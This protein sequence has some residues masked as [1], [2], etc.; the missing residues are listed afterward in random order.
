MSLRRRVAAGA[1]WLIIGR[2]FVRLIGVTSTVILARLLVPEDFGLIALAMSFVALIDIMSAFS[3]DLALI[4]DNKAGQAEY[5]AAWSMG[6][7]KGVAGAIV[8]L[9]A[10]DPLASYFAEPKLLMTLYILALFIL[11]RGF[12]NIGIVDFRK[13]LEFDKEFRFNVYLKLAGFFATV[14][15]AYILRDYRALLVGIIV[16]ALARVALSYVMSPYR[17]H[18]NLARWRPI[19]RFS[20]WLLANNLLI[21]LNQRSATFILGKTVGMRATGLFSI[22]EEIGNLVTTELVWPVQRAVFPGYTMVS[23]DRDRLRDG[24]MD[25]LTVVMTVG[26]PLAIGMACCSEQFVKLFLGQAWLE[27]APLISIMALAGAVSLC[28]ANSGSVFMATGQTYLIAAI[29]AALAVIRLP[30]LIYAIAYWQELGAAYALMLSALFAVMLNWAVVTRILHFSLITLL[31][32]V[33]RP[34]LAATIMGLS[35]LALEAQFPDAAGLTDNLAQLT[36]LIVAGCLL[37]ISV[38]LLL[39]QACRKP[40]GAESFILLFLSNSF[41]NLQSGF[42]RR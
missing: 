26:L 28:S 30:A 37:Y 31:S 8:L 14:L 20:K 32:R 29:A 23:H 15:T 33:W 21:F 7:I 27:I 4:A 38:I 18:W 40:D 25:V 11:L 12:E 17:P 19:M 42:A 24:Y 34:P 6:V 9:L 5:D 13:Y 3:F 39:W 36:A 1:V 2:I 35:L 22:A 16:Q 10:A 41:S